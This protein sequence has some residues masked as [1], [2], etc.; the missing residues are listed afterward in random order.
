[1]Q[2]AGPERRRPAQCHLLFYNCRSVAPPGMRVK[3]RETV[4]ALK[5]LNSI[6]QGGAQRNPGYSVR[7]ATSP[8]RAAQP[9][10]PF[11]GSISA[12]SETQG[13]ATLHPGLIYSALSA[14]E[15]SHRIFNPVA[16]EAG[17]APGSYFRDSA[18]ASEAHLHI[19]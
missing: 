5:P 13:S 7:G 17:L 9:V 4:S 8:E 16:L 12:L 2:K 14:L 15:P 18:T 6:A 19:Q 1:M 11:Q 3:L 10:S